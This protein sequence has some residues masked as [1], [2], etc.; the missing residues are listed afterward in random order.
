MIFHEKEDEIE[1]LYSDS[2]H[3]DEIVEYLMGL[4]FIITKQSAKRSV[5]V[6]KTKIFF[7][8]R[9]TIKKDGDVLQIKG[10]NQY[11]EL[12]SDYQVR[13]RSPRVQRFAG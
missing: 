13:Y 4:D 10:K 12:L 2:S 11:I 3:F 6:K 9:I 5:L 7:S 1:L 8:D